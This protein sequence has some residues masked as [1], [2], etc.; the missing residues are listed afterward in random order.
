M[1]SD[2]V[3]V[4]GAVSDDPFPQCLSFLKVCCFFVLMLYQNSAATAA[5]G[6]TI[7]FALSNAIM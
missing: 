7:D 4:V 5:N 2:D 1:L 6:C 3:V